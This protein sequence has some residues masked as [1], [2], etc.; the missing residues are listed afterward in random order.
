MCQSSRGSPRRHL[1]TAK[2]IPT[3]FNDIT[4]GVMPFT[5]ALI[6]SSICII[7][8]VTQPELGPIKS[9][10]FPHPF[11]LQWQMSRWKLAI[12]YCSRVFIADRHDVSLYAEL[13]A[14][15]SKPVCFCCVLSRAVHGVHFIFQTCW[16]G[17]FFFSWSKTT[18]FMGLQSRGLNQEDGPRMV[19]NFT[20]SLYTNDKCYVAQPYNSL[21]SIIPCVNLAQVSMKDN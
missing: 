21:S 13:S 9:W 3:P 5:I 14:N 11:P 12:I 10:S 2:L 15:A 1:Q 16:V 18:R 19:E 4:F 17:V 7:Q 6:L 8:P 20:V